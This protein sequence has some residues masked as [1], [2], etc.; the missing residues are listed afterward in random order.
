[1]TIQ[2]YKINFVST[3]IFYKK[4]LPESN[5]FCFLTLLKQVYVSRVP[6]AIWVQTK[7]FW[8]A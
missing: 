1:M 2:R 3:P 6:N 8:E 7:L 5:F 4:K